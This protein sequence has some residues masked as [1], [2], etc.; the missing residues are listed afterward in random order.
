MKKI[1]VVNVNWMGDVIFSI[2][3]FKALKK[4]YPQ[5][6]LTCLAVPRVRGILEQSPYVDNI[7]SYDEK[8]EDRTPWA[9]WK[10]IQRIRE[11]QFDVAFI[12]HRSLTRALLVF[13]AGIPQRI[14]YDTKGRG[15]LLT[16]R[17]R[18]PQE[19]L[20][21]C[22]YYLKIIEEYGIKVDD[23]ICDLQLPEKEVYVMER[24]LESYGIS[25]DDFVIVVHV[26][27]NWNLKRWPAD[28]FAM[29]IR[30]LVK[31]Y[32]AKIVIPGTH[33]DS[34]LA[35]LIS[36]KSKVNPVILTGQ[37]NL[38]GL[39][40]LMRRA[41]LVISSDSGPIHLASGLGTDVI[42]LFGPTRHEITGPRGKGKVFILQNDV[43]CNR[44]P[45]YYLECPDNSCMQSITVDHVLKTIKK[46]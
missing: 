5:A 18:M 45:C 24:L 6:I 29:L 23:R 8:G 20:H 12:L 11:Q 33:D 10:L 34:S 15:W 3:V 25:R 19:K 4:A 30:R 27:G 39:M 28:Y 32:Q 46:I 35:E 37:T 22:D 43:G 38:K 41:N 16:K 36:Q 21:R 31:D 9:K 42:G 7:L 40:A 14:G 26:G 2:P 44:H 17:I 13:L 1:L